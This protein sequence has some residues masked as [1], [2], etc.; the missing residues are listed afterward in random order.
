MARVDGGPESLLRLDERRRLLGQPPLGPD[1]AHLRRPTRRVAGAGRHRHRHPGGARDRLRPRR[2]SLVGDPRPRRHPGTPSTECSTTRQAA[3]TLVYGKWPGG[4][5]S[6]SS[7]A[8]DSTAL[9]NV[10]TALGPG[11]GHRRRLVDQLGVQRAAVR[12]R[13]VAAGRLR[14]PHH[15]RDGHHHPERHRGRRA[16]PAHR[17]G[18]RQRHQHVA[19]RR[20]RQAADR[21]AALRRDAVG[22]V[23][24]GRHQ[25]RLARGPVRHHRLHRHAVRRVRVRP[26]GEPAA[27][28]RGARTAAG[29]GCRA[30]GSGFR[31]ARPPRLRGRTRRRAVRRRDG[32][33]RRRSRST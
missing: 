25:R 10:A 3:P 7:S 1:A 8:A 11:R 4:R 20:T 32:V 12:R 27:H 29:F 5:M 31:S 28:R 15:E 2:R 21:R 14:P 33:S 17:G 19:V 30:M 18:H 26:A 16:G 9:P 23:H 6:V 13:S 22:P 24:R